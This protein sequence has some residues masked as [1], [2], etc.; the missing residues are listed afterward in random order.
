MRT[1]W[2]F[3]H[4]LC[5]QTLLFIFRSCLFSHVFYLICYT[6]LHCLFYSL[7]HQWRFIVYL[8]CL[9]YW[10]CF[11][12]FR[13]MST[14][15]PMEYV[16][17]HSLQSCSTEKTRAQ[18]CTMKFIGELLVILITSRFTSRK[19]THVFRIPLLFH[20]PLALPPFIPLSM[21]YMK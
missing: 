8:R 14:L 13:V 20:W 4:K 6:Q 21:S 2:D 9:F 18:V 17:L 1:V 5:K 12:L 3:I 15:T 19:H 16:P 11:W 10:Q 7:L